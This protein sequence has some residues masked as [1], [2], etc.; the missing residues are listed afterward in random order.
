GVSRRPIR[1]K[2]TGCGGTLCYRDESLDSKVPNIED[3][4]VAI[5]IDADAVGRVELAG[6]V[7][8]SPELGQIVAVRVELLDAVVVQVRDVDITVGVDIDAGRVVELTVAAPERTELS[9]VLAVEVEYLDS[10]VIAVGH[11]DALAV[12]R[13]IDRV[14]ELAV[15]IA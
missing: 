3:E 14:I 6:A 1:G 7:P 8:S 2:F 15:A 12:D 10:M 13:D 11:V 9:Q 5:P 4:D